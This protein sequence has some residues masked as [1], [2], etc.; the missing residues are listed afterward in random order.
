VQLYALSHA[1]LFS[2]VQRLQYFSGLHATDVAAPSTPIASHIKLLGVT[3]DSSRSM[4][5][6][7][8]LVSQSCFYHIRALHHICGV[9]D[10]TIAVDIAFAL[11]SSTLNYANSVLCGSLAKNITCLQRVKNA[12][13]RV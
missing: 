2:T 8:K 6:H 7:T 4:A 9:S 13:V 1:I 12:A 11:V 3:L 5:K 10:R